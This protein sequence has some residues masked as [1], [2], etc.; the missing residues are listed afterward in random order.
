MFY[1]S[2]GVADNFNIISDGNK[3]EVLQIIPSQPLD[4]DHH[5]KAKDGLHSQTHSFHSSEQQP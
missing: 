2:M 5:Q 1:E 3:D 4:L